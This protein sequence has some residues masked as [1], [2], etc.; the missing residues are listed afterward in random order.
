[1]HSED[2]TDVVDMLL[3]GSVQAQLSH[4]LLLRYQLQLFIL[5]ENVLKKQIF[6][7]LCFGGGQLWRPQ[8]EAVCA[9]LILWTPW[10]TG[11]VVFPLCPAVAVGAGI[12]LFREQEFA[13]NQCDAEK[14]KQSS[15]WG[16]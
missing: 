7:C 1:M 5:M 14:E 2:S 15:S 13:G 9:P 12:L 8:G 16:E 4:Q 11:A 6:K 10:P 3:L